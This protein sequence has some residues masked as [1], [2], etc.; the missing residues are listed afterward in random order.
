[1][2]KTF[3]SYRREDAPSEAARIADRL[4]AALG[5]DHV[6]FD[7]DTLQGGDLF[8]KIIEERIDVC[9]VLLVIIGKTWLS[10]RLA[11]ETDWVRHEVERALARKIRVIPVL[12]SK[13]AQ[14]PTAAELPPSL[15]ELP[16]HNAVE[17]VYGPVFEYQMQA[18]IDALSGRRRSS[19]K[20][21][22]RKAA[23]WLAGAL[24]ASVIGGFIWNK[25]TFQ[26]RPPDD[27]HLQLRVQLDPKL[28]PVATAPV[29]KLRQRLP[30]DL[31]T[32]ELAPAAP[33][34]SLEFEYQPQFIFMPARNQQYQGDLHREVTG[35]FAIESPTW[36]SICFERKAE[37]LAA[38]PTVRFR[39]KEGS[40]CELAEDDFGWATACG[41][42]HSLLD[43]LIPAVQAA[44]SEVFARPAWAVPALSTLRK[45]EAEKRNPAYSE[46]VLGSEPVPALKA[47]DRMV[48]SVRVNG[49]PLFFD[50]L[51]PDS[52]PFDAAKGIHLSFG[53]ENLNFSG[54]NAGF[55]DMDLL[56]E[57]KKDTDVIGRLRI[58]V[59]CIAL[60][61]MPKMP[62]LSQGRKMWWKAEYHPGNQEDI[63]QL[64]LLSTRSP[65]A[66]E[67]FKRRLDA[68]KLR[69]GTAGLVAVI[70]PPINGSESYGVIL[71]VQQPSGQI[72]FTF[73]EGT[74]RDLC[75]G[76]NAVARASP[77]F[78]KSSFRRSV[79]GRQ[80]SIACSQM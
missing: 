11:S 23:P 53:L 26:V 1:M 79:S 69:I 14:L 41:V 56:M 27:F 44:A 51:P 57:F 63:Y 59:R 21:L 2:P 74:S 22:W 6:F 3:I 9:D 62:L 15:V 80:D 73:D 34:G 38:S 50:G 32:N 31:G 42:T 8:P 18:L 7:V 68:A 49:S 20:P 46:F 33:R 30:K 76:M 29:M 54:Q 45:L 10:P 12:V 39:C 47:A 71:G 60:R 28:G 72:K 35:G 61:T 66:T 4:R 17:V 70:R 40:A 58:P 16:Q 65:Q 43:R 5:E 64:F 24:V 48:Y 77:L 55:E 52:V 75:R 36:S 67:Q 19:P 13:D 25:S 78:G 37:S